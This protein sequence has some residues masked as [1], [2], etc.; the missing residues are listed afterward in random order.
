[1][2]DHRAVEVLER[3]RDLVLGGAGVDD[4]RLS[5]LFGQLQLRFED[6]PLVFP[7]RVV[8]VEIE[9]DLADRNSVPG[10]SSE[11]LERFPVSR[12]MGMDSDRDGHTV[13][14]RGELARLL[15][16]LEA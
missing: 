12:L 6:M 10:E 5:E 13:F 3:M 14:A 15:G 16:G 9:P 8:A 4:H 7:R 11:R 1:M 2:H